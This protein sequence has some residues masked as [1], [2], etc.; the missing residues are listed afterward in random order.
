MFFRRKK[1]KTPEISHIEVQNLLKAALLSQARVE[2]ATVGVGTARSTLPCAFIKEMGKTLRE[3]LGESGR[4]A[5]WYDAAEEEL[6]MLLTFS[7]KEGSEEISLVEECLDSFDLDDEDEKLPGDVCGIETCYVTSK[8]VTEI[9]F[10]SCSVAAGELAR[11]ADRLLSQ[12]FDWL[13]IVYES[14]EEEFDE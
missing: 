10:T 5:V 4:V 11:A 14:F 12:V 1:E 2:N 9:H 6:T 13:D 3:D 8:D 7:Y